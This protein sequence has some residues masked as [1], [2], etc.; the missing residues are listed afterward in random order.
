MANPEL[1][2]SRIGRTRVRTDNS[3][4]KDHVQVTNDFANN[5]ENCKHTIEDVCHSIKS[6]LSHC[7]R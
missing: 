1:C 3:D 4:Y 2:K 5:R 7:I 6:Q